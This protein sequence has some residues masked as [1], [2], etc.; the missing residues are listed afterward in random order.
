MT[1]NYTCPQCDGPLEQ[2]M[3]GEFKC[4]NCGLNMTEVLENVSNRGGAL[5]DV[6]DQLLNSMVHQDRQTEQINTKHEKDDVNIRG[7]DW[8]G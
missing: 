1:E 5:Q 6:A 4:G 3:N 2:R 8:D 7:I